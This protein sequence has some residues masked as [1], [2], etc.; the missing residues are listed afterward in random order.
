LALANVAQVVCYDHRGNGRSDWGSPEDW[1][2]DTWA[3]DV[4]RLCD[5]LGIE[6]PVIVGAS[7]GGFVAQRYI[8]RH[9]DHPS[10]VAL[11]C[12]APR[13]NLDAMEKAFA[14]QG[15]EIAGTIAKQLFSGDM[16]VLA[17]FL[18][19]CIPLYSTEPPDPDALARVVINFDLLGHFFAGEGASMDL[20]AGLAAARC[21]VLVVAGELDPVMPVAMTQELAPALPAEL[22]RY[23]LLPG[24]SHL[25]VGGKAATEAVREFIRG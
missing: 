21:P 25:Q 6:R 24:V 3:D 23:E 2:L 16:S 9:P 18:E 4:V 1:T 14:D 7:F 15:G 19:S 13:V 11:L 22:A 17:D 20:R 8:A 10:K 12:T 5:V